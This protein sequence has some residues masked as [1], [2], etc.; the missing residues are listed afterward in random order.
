MILYSRHLNRHSEYLMLG[1]TWNSE[2]F[3]CP[4]IKQKPRNI[5][6]VVWNAKPLM[7][8]HW[9]LPLIFC[10]YFEMPKAAFFKHCVRV[11][12]RSCGNLFGINWKQKGFIPF[13]LGLIE[14]FISW[15]FFIRFVRD[16][17]FFCNKWAIYYA[18]S[19]AHV[20]SPSRTRFHLQFF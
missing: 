15:L 10:L 8:L 5:L 16:S 17:V 3:F 12:S 18:N 14:L 11:L 2:T 9:K 1:W 20:V 4:W 6:S 7:S 13:P 19:S